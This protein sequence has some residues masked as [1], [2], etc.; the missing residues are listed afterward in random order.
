MKLAVRGDT[1]ALQRLMVC[2]HPPL[3]RLLEGEIERR[4]RR[5]IDPDDVLQEAYVSAFKSAGDCRFDGPG[6]FYRWL[7]AIVRSRL[8]NQIRSL[9][10][11]KRDVD[12][13]VAW[14]PG[15]TASY[16]ALI[17]RLPSPQ[18]TPSR[19][20]SREEATAAMLSCLAQ[21][22]DDQRSAIK[23]RFLEERP[24]S[25]IASCLGK[26]ETAVH[27]LFHRGLKAL[28]ELMGS[29]TSYLTRT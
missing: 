5:H 27:M 10:Q 25:E 6:A 19:Q 17:D 22:T 18:S 4:F 1:D 3:R 12:R 23:M 9:K 7:E 2:Y 8:K 16:S 13:E 24:V 15:A 11:Q 28:R 29:I 20:V 14:L 21:L 26:S